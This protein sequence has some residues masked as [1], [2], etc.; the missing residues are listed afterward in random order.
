METH[1][2]KD[3]VGNF[4]FTRRAAVAVGVSVLIAAVLRLKSAPNPKF[5]GGWHEIP[6]NEYCDPT[7]DDGKNG[8]ITDK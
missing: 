7:S 3:A 6:V 4:V 5:K 1:L 8:Q 2:L